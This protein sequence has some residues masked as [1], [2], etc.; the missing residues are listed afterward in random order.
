MEGGGLIECLETVVYTN[1]TCT[2]LNLER[3]GSGSCF[4]QPPLPHYF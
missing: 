1:G 3:S 4:L 2:N